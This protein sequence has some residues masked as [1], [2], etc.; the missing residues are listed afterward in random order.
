MRITHGITSPAIRTTP[1]LGRLI[2]PGRRVTSKSLFNDAMNC[3]VASAVLLATVPLFS[4]LYMVMVKGSAQFR[5]AMFWQLPPGAGMVGGGFGNALLGTFLIVLVA[6]L[7]SVP[8]GVGTAV[9]LTEFHQ[10]RNL[11]RLVRFSAKILSG[12]PS[13]LAGVFVFATIVTV[14]QKF[15]LFAGGIALAV[16]MLPIITLA[17]EEALLRVPQQLREASLALGATVSQTVF[18]VTIP[19]ARSFILTGL[20]LAVA[21]ASGESAPLIFTALFSDYWINSLFQPTASLS[22]LIYNFSAVPYENQINLAWAA[23][24]I[25]I[26]GVLVANITTRIFS[27]RNP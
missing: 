10:Q 22:V 14:T 26:L 8:I 13:I 17:T 5:L 18:K 6:T 9:Y 23:S 4:V 3:L 1:R 25:L 24:L 2:A 7:I 27:D 16:L 21:R 12:L 19:A 11:A 15:S 20:S